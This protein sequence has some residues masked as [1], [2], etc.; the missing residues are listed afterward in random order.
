MAM[1]RRGEIMGHQ[2]VRI[3]IIIPIISSRYETPVFQK[4]VKSVY[5]ALQEQPLWQIVDANKTEADL[6]VELMEIVINKIEN[7][8]LE[9]PAKMW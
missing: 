1:G 2:I 5:E 9:E 3:V 4:K 6:N 8:E 7:L